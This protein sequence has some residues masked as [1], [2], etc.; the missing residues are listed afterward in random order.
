MRKK[1]W[2]LLTTPSFWPLFIQAHLSN[3]FRVFN[4]N[5]VVYQQLDDYLNLLDLNK[6]TQNSCSLFCLRAISKWLLMDVR[7]K[8][9]KKIINSEAAKRVML[10]NV[11]VSP[12]CPLS[13]MLIDFSLLQ[14]SIT[15][16][17]IPT[18]F[19]GSMDFLASR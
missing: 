6:L 1:S 4:K 13:N 11:N 14:I 19:I 17:E 9:E 12:Q 8:S 7:S 18:K 10:R 3:P 15:I 5:L 16:Y 2:P